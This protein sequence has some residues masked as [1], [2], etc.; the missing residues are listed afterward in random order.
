MTRQPHLNAEPDEI[1]VALD[2]T[3]PVFPATI[4]WHRRD[5]WAVPHF[6]YPVARAILS[7]LDDQTEHPGFHWRSGRFDRDSLILTDRQGNHSRITADATGRYRLADDP[8]HWSISAPH[9]GTQA[10]ITVEANRRALAA[11]AGEDLVT[12]PSSGADPVFPAVVANRGHRQVVPYFRRA[13]ANAIMAWINR[14][15]L[16]NPRDCNRAYWDRDTVVIVTAALVG[17][18]GYLPTRIPP[19]ADGRYCIG[20]GEWEWKK[21]DARD[22]VTRDEVVEAFVEGC[23]LVSTAL[24]LDQPNIDLIAVIRETVLGCLD[25]PGVDFD[26]LAATLFDTDPRN[27]GIGTTSPRIPRVAPD[28]RQK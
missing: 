2:P 6:R 17:E 7:W 14:L 23:G 18:D 26:T 28:D 3:G 12:L 15:Y 21:L 19:D 5:G 16:A 25:N 22:L 24:M 11:D 8:W 10:T 4:D 1:Y 27:G 9:P 20:G 13:V